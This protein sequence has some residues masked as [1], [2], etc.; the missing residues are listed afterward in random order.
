MFFGRSDEAPVGAALQTRRPVLAPS[1]GEMDV[2]PC[3][4]INRRL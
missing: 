3:T 1:D 2:G 4:G